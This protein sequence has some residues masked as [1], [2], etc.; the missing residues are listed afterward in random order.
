MLIEKL[1][2]YVLVSEKRGRDFR[3]FLFHTTYITSG[4]KF[5]FGRAKCQKFT[6]LP[7]S[8]QREGVG[9]S[10]WPQLPLCHHPCLHSFKPSRMCAPGLSQAGWAL[11]STAEHTGPEKQHSTTGWSSSQGG[12]F[13]PVHC[14]LFWV[15]FRLGIKEGF[16]AMRA[17]LTILP[18]SGNHMGSTASWTLFFCSQWWITF[19]GSLSL[20]YN[21]C[22]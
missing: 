12:W 17:L 10:W 15:F 18:L 22:H 14:G 13:V 9:V 16:E 11:L 8:V 1:Q 19:C 20:L 6:I 5:S 4:D 2:P 3:A 21:F 7:G